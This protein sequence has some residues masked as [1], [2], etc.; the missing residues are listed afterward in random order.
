MDEKLHQSVFSDF[1]GE[2][3]EGQAR[4][5]EKDARTHLKS[6]KVLLLPPDIQN[7]KDHRDPRTISSLAFLRRV[8][9]DVR[10]ANR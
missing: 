7:D 10:I 4:R 5:T 1:K 8:A 9:V 3:R 2:L 6:M